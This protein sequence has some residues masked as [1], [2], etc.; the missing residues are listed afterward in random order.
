MPKY[1]SV[2]RTR[3]GHTFRSGVFDLSPE[4][5]AD[6]TEHLDENWGDIGMI[7]INE[8]NGFTC[9][10][11]DNLSALSFSVVDEN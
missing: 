5:V 9:V 1:Q 7:R 10:P 8:E 3:D 6:L 11:R 2:A 4:E